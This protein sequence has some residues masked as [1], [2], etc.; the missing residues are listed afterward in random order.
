MIS[1]LIKFIILFIIIYLVIKLV[2]FFILLMK[3][4]DANIN[5]APKN[6]NS[7]ENKKNKDSDVI[8]LKKDQYRVD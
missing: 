4:V 7:A 6:N 1:S 2:R 5:A 8:E 3:T